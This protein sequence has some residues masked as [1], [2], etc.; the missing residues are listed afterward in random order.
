MLGLYPFV[1]GSGA[2]RQLA[3]TSTSSGVNGQ[4][5]AI[6]FTPTINQVMIVLSGLWAR[7]AHLAG[8]SFSLVLID[9]L[10]V[11]DIASIFDWPDDFDNTISHAFPGPII[12]PPLTTL[13]IRMHGAAP[14]DAALLTIRGFWTVLRLPPTA[15]YL[16]ALATAVSV[17]HLT[18]QA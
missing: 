8:R 12:V 1:L 14:V 10:T 5:I 16:D 18:G 6:P 17:E 2:F 4:L 3:R 7:G 11:S 15:R 13:N 9:Q